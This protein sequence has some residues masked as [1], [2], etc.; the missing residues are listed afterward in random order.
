MKAEA[1]AMRE[2]LLLKL[3]EEEEARRADREF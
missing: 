2:A 1:E 3:A